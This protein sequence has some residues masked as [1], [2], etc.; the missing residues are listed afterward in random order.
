LSCYTINPVVAKYK[1]KDG[2]NAFANLKM[3]N[4]MPMIR[5]IS[6][7]EKPLQVKFSES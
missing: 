4:N 2:Q 6:Q 7:S 3:V 1:K 5:E